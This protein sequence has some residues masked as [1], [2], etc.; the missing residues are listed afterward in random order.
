M[1][2]D[3]VRFGSDFGLAQVCNQPAEAVQ[4]L[5][6]V[7]RNRREYLSRSQD[8]AFSVDEVTLEGGSLGDVSTANL[9]GV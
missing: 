8:L 1:W 3:F 4:L 7:I 5:E 6:T 9:F 2:F